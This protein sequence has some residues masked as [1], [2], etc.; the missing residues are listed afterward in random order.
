MTK[1]KLRKE[2]EPASVEIDPPVAWC[3]IPK[4]KE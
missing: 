3:E 1:E 2:A 4:Y